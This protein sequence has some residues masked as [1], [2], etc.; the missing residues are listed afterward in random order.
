MVHERSFGIERANEFFEQILIPQYEDFLKDPLSPRY[1]LLAIV[2]AYHMYDWAFK[3][4]FT[5]DDFNK[6][7]PSEKAALANLKIAQD[8]ANG[9]KHFEK[10]SKSTAHPKAKA[11]TKT[12]QREGSFS[13]A[14]SPAFSIPMLMIQKDDGS[15]ISADDLL[16]N[17]IGFWKGQQ[18]KGVF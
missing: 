2:A 4:K 15:Q 18:A 5:E 7:Y 9:T 1:A 8:I 11:K 6:R 17:L 16:E 13:R 10:P 3:R 12:F 14:F